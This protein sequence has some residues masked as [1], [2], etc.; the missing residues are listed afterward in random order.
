MIRLVLLSD[1]HIFPLGP[2]IEEPKKAQQDQH[3]PGMTKSPQD[4][5]RHIF[6]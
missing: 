5:N 4:D 2:T 1:V 6:M 3:L